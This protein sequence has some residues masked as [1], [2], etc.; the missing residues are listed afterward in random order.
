M[1]A[2][3]FLSSFGSMVP[4]PS[5]SKRS[6]ASLISSISSSVRRGRSYSFG[7]NPA[8]AG[9]RE[10]LPAIYYECRSLCF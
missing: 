8:F 7:L 10:P 4:D 3:P 6:K 5:A 2:S 9:A 1:I